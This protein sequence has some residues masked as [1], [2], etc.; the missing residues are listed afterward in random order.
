MSN[1]CL[2]LSEVGMVSIGS[3]L[4][5]VN[6]D[7]M[8]QIQS[9][10]R[11]CELQ[12]SR[13]NGKNIPDYTNKFVQMHYILKYTYGYAFEY[14][15]VYSNI[16]FDMINNTASINNLNI[17]SLGC[18]NYVD[19]YGL[20]QALERANLKDCCVNYTGVDIV[21]WSYK[22]E[23]RLNDNLNFELKNITEYINSLSIFDF[24]VLFFPKSISELREDDITKIC[25]KFEN[26]KFKNDVFYL[27]VPVRKKDGSCYYDSKKIE[28]LKTA[29]ENNNFTVKYHRE[30]SGVIDTTAND[31][32][33][34]KDLDNMFEY[35]R[36]I[37]WNILKNSCKKQ[38]T[39]PTN[40]ANG[41]NLC[42]D[43]DYPIL[44]T[45]QARYQIIKFQRS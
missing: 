5:D 37:R 40:Q 34:I 27:A 41:C 7:F 3:Y 44:K 31:Y 24:D 17:L 29:I 15:T 20:V 22:F 42:T 19:Y 1:R 45:S 14:K 2:E 36:S 33:Y 38:Y 16:L 32:P 4:E 26:A 23:K 21:D 39:C 13:Y 30:Y 18:G 43:T 11:L 12:K 8:Y 35:P 6:E 9:K 28:S 25:T 10:D